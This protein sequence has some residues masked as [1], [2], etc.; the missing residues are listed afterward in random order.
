[1]SAVLGFRILNYEPELDELI[2]ENTANITGEFSE[3]TGTLALSGKAP[4]SEYISFIRN[5]KY[6]YH[7]ETLPLNHDKVVYFTLSDG[8]LLSATEDRYIRLRDQFVDPVLVTGFTPDLAGK[9]QTWLPIRENDISA[10]YRDAEVRVFDKRGRLVFETIGF[11]KRW[12]GTY[13]GEPLPSDGYFF[14]VDLKLPFIKKTYKG[15]V[16]LLR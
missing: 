11:E 3:E 1:V 9:N 8:T 14:T 15:V 2:F 7:G 5:V 6:I 16:T 4:A 13:Q 10:D 12:D